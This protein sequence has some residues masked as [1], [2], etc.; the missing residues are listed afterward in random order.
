[1]AM[2]SDV[3]QNMAEDATGPVKEEIERCLK[4]GLTKGQIF[5]RLRNM[6]FAPAICYAGRS[7]GSIVS[8]PGVVGC[9]GGITRPQATTK[10][11]SAATLRVQVTSRLQCLGRRMQRP[12]RARYC[13][14]RSRWLPRRRR[15]HSTHIATTREECC[16][17]QPTVTVPARAEAPSACQQPA[18]CRRLRARACRTPATLFST[19]CPTAGVQITPPR[20]LGLSQPAWQALLLC[21]LSAAAVP[22]PF[23]VRLALNTT[24]SSRVTRQS[25]GGTQSP[26]EHFA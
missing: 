18:N 9:C 24:S 10:A 22:A 12:R 16:G 14:H 20:L 5:R 13:H 11:A 15:W 19:R 2:P 17:C 4:A 7:G 26:A 25:D 23:T 6:G 8:L 21:Q 1:M 3:D